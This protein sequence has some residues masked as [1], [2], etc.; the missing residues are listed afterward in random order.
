M[1]DLAISR[2][3][4][5][6]RTCELGRLVQRLGQEKQRA[7]AQHQLFAS[8]LAADFAKA[9]EIDKSQVQR[10][11][12]AVIYEKKNSVQEYKLINSKAWKICDTFFPL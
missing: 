4:V 11:C 9:A 10:K 8:A 1:S 6:S 3:H 7:S 5:L 2:L 12:S